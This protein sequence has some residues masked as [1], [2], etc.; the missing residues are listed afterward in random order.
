M[1]NNCFDSLPVSFQTM[2]NLREVTY[3]TMISGFHMRQYNTYNHDN[4]DSVSEK[5]LFDPT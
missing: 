4:F 5:R 2:E 1:L 3:H